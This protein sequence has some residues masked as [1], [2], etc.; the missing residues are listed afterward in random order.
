SHALA[1][2]KPPEFG[3]DAV[4]L[5][6]VCNGLGFVHQFVFLSG[7]FPAGSFRCRK[8]SSPLFFTVKQ[9]F[10]KIKAW[11]EQNAREN[12]LELVQLAIAK[13][14]EIKTNDSAFA[15]FTGRSRSS[16]DDPESICRRHCRRGCGRPLQYVGSRRESRW[17]GGRLER[18]WAVYGLRSDR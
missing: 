14:Q 8:S 2:P 6:A 4:L 3:A 11:P 16:G 15:R 13:T 17:I 9:F 1:E 18:N 7:L 10:L 5:E 12:T